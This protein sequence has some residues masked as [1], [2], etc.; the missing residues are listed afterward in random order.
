MAARGQ[1]N[2]RGAQDYSRRSETYNK[3]KVNDIKNYSI[4]D[5]VYYQEKQVDDQ[6]VQPEVQVYKTVAQ[7]EVTTAPVN[8]SFPGMKNQNTSPYSVLIQFV[9]TVCFYQYS[10]MNSHKQPPLL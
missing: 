3:D 5:N 6:L 10:T 4:E 1:G 2:R 9:H 8:Q 7:D